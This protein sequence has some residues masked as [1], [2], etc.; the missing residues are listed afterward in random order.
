MKGRQGWLAGPAR[1]RLVVSGG[2]RSVH[3]PPE[4][5]DREDQEGEGGQPVDHLHVVE[6]GP[7]HK[8]VWVEEILTPHL[9]EAHLG[10]E[11]IP[12]GGRW[13]IP[14]GRRE[15]LVPHLQGAQLL[16]RGGNPGESWGGRVIGGGQEVRERSRHILN[17]PRV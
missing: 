5:W 2:V 10:G 8:V 9:E 7:E 17:V 1:T 11:E 3:A 4:Q 12:G 6:G 15:V 16:P 14:R 13:G